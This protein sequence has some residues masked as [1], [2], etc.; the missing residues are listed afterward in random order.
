MLLR[1]YFYAWGQ[2]TDA[3]QM[4]KFSRLT[5]SFYSIIRMRQKTLFNYTRH[6]RK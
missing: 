4:V 6:V 2:Q 5:D 3:Y 1:H